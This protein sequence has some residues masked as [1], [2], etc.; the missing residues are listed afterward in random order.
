MPMYVVEVSMKTR[1]GLCLLFACWLCVV[2]QIQARE[3]VDLQ[4]II[5]QAIAAGQ[6]RIV[7]PSGVYRVT[8]KH[9]THLRL[10][11]LEDV[12]IEGCGS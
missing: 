9:R 2:P 7:I 1:Y 4:A 8:P 3:T 12:E 5:D 6:K 11:D 10:T